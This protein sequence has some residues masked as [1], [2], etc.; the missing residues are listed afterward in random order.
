MEE[1][2]QNYIDRL[3]NEEDIIPVSEEFY[4]DTASYNKDINCNIDECIDAYNKYSIPEEPVKVEEDFVSRI[5]NEDKASSGSTTNSSVKNAVGIDVT[6]SNSEK[7]NE[8]IEIHQENTSTPDTKQIVLEEQQAHTFKEEALNVFNQA[9]AISVNKLEQAGNK[10]MRAPVDEVTHSDKNFEEGY[11]TYT[12]GIKAAEDVITV[13]GLT[14][15]ANSELNTIK[16]V[17]KACKQMDKLV[18]E[19]TIS[20]DNLSLSKEELNQK[21][22]S[23]GVD[24]DVRRSIVKN[25]DLISERCI[26]QSKLKTADTNIFDIHTTKGQQALREYL[27]QSDNGVVRYAG[28]RNFSTNVHSKLAK[29]KNLKKKNI[30]GTDKSAVKMSSAIAKAQ[31]SKRKLGNKRKRVVVSRMTGAINKSVACDANFSS[32]FAE[33]NRTARLLG[34]AKSV[35]VLTTRLAYKIL[36]GSKRGGYKGL[37]SLTVKG[38]LKTPPGRAVSDVTKKALKYSLDKIRAGKDLIKKGAVTA[39]NAAKTAVNNTKLVNKTKK[40]F[41]RV[42]NSSGVKKAANVAKKTAKVT[43]KGAKVVGKPV[44]VAGKAVKGTFGAVS[45]VFSA[46]NTLKKWIAIALVA[47]VGIFIIVCFACQAV[48]SIIQ[49]GNTSTE[50]ILA[51]DDVFMRD[52]IEELS[53][54]FVDRKKYAVNK[55]KGVPEN[56]D[57]WSENDGGTVNIEAYDTEHKLIKY[58][59]PDSSGEWVKGYKVYYV[60]HDGRIITDATNNIKDVLCLAYVQM[61][62]LGLPWSEE[63]LDVINSYINKW[64]EWLNGDNSDIYIEESDLYSCDTGCSTMSYMCNDDCTLDKISSV[65]FCSYSDAAES[66]R[67]GT[68]LFD[69]NEVRYNKYGDFCSLVC[70]HAGHSHGTRRVIGE[71]VFSEC[72]DYTVTK[73]CNGHNVSVCYGH[74]DVVIKIPMRTMEDA[75]NE[76]YKVNGDNSGWTDDEKEWIKILAATDWK[77]LYWADPNELTIIQ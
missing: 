16:H 20:V 36:I 55:G 4:S 8:K 48:L 74:R 28:S 30:E 45:K 40:T 61:N 47:V 37:V 38:M 21:L 6:G 15:V 24:S 69:G 72:D 19:K 9:K 11:E 57:T 13:I 1:K 22:K 3:I 60:N 63:N 29:N 10:I 53:E 54:R 51:Y 33:F 32:G 2:E 66:V 49:M 42:K 68:K 31:A 23:A 67:K 59:H 44:K 52:K 71:P 58:G 17:D 5:I 70:N 26:M 18:G 65:S 50:V 35:G 46:L 25:K 7:L 43:K 75:F 27:K 12:K 56:T 14:S 62:S 73:C 41:N 64:Y 39:K 76:S 34:K 77:G